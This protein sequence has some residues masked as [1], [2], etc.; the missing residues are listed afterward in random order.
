MQYLKA[1]HGAAC[2]KDMT[3]QTAKVQKQSSHTGDGN[4][5]GVRYL[6]LRM[7]IATE[8]LYRDKVSAAS[9]ESI[10]ASKL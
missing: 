1:M 4:T 6:N 8:C 10:D 7:L 2:I 3:E 9:F 5:L